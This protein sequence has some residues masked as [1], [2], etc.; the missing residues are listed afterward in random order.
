MYWLESAWF[1]DSPLE[2]EMCSP[3]FQAF[4]FKFN[5]LCRYDAGTAKYPA[6]L[7]RV[8]EAPLGDATNANKKGGA[9]KLKGAHEGAKKG[10][11]EGATK[12][13]AAQEGAKGAEEGA[14]KLK[15]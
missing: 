7:K 11:E 1:G 12:A 5:V 13:K 2:P 4:A 9:K 10:V 8:A 6:T 15:A 14:K 3:G